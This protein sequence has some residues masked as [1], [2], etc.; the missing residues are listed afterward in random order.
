MT[1]KQTELFNQEKARKEKEKE[2]LLTNLFRKNPDLNPLKKANIYLFDLFS[3]TE[4]EKVWKVIQNDIECL[5]E[6]ILT[7]R[8]D[9]FPEKAFCP[10]V[11]KEIF[12]TGAGN[13][14]EFFVR[15]Q[16][17]RQGMQQFLVCEK[18]RPI[19]M[20]KIGSKTYLEIMKEISRDKKPAKR[21]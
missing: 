3:E 4:K 18:N 7:N 14:V 20:D 5:L 10:A 16:F 12:S 21:R 2:N 1:S 9:V 6:L 13:I 19:I 8:S 11:L 15:S 17:Y